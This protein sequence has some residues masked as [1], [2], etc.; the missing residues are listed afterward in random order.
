MSFSPSLQ[1]FSASFGD[2]FLW[3]WGRMEKSMSS[4]LGQGELKQL[5]FLKDFYIFFLLF[6]N[7][8]LRKEMLGNGRLF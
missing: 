8:V 5:R 2:G 1:V 7:G 6:S 4:E 3:V